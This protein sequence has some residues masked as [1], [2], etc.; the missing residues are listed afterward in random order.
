MSRHLTRFLSI[1]HLLLSTFILLILLPYFLTG[2]YYT[3]SMASQLRYEK[4]QDMEHNADHVLVCLTNM[5]QE[6]ERISYL[7]VVDHDLSRI[8]RTRH[9]TYDNAYYTD[10]IRMESAIKDATSVNANILS[11]IFYSSYGN[12]YQVNHLSSAPV[13]EGE[14]WLEQSLSAPDRCYVGPVQ[15]NGVSMRVLP[16]V[17]ALYDSLD[18][19]CIGY[20][21][22]DYNLD[23]LLRSCL[24]SISPNASLAVYQNGTLLYD[25]GSLAGR[26]AASSGQSTR[27]WQAR[28]IRLGDTQCTA[29]LLEHEKTGLQALLY[30][31]SDVLS[32][33]AMQRLFLYLLFLALFLLGDLIISAVVI[34]RIGRSIQD[35]AQAMDSA[36][37]GERKRLEIAGSVVIQTELDTLRQSYNAMISRLTE[38]AEREAAAILEQKNTQIRVLES[39]INPHFLYNTLNL[40]ASLAELEHQTAIQTVAVDMA[41]VFRYA[42]RGSSMVTLE[43]ELRETEAYTEIVRLRFPER[44][45]IE[46]HADPD[47]ISCMVPKLLL[48]PLL[49]NSVKYGMESSVNLLHVIIRISRM[50]GD[51]LIRVQDDGPGIRRDRLSGLRSRLRDYVPGMSQGD[52]TSIGLLNVHARVRARF[53]S[54]YG[55]MIE[56]VPSGCAVSILLPWTLQQDLS[57]ESPVSPS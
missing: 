50:A 16:V 1:R 46:V 34:G 21:R 23:Q 37:H 41:R 15:T 12:V 22:I 31:S 51:V 56:D 33:P 2:I 25:S 10:E 57:S 6:T 53:G 39:Q 28:Q 44:L 36:K 14:D 5:M 7:P 17:Y 24:D 55:V 48:Q 45:T 35:L 26:E 40:I 18:N 4:E 27:Q 11:V 8:L 42:I 29:C 9:E 3:A 19:N 52:G 13:P 43:E 49:E 38:S 32:S 20:A 47:T 30:I 54:P